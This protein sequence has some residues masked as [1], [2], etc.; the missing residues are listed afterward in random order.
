[1]V[2]TKLEGNDY[3]TSYHLPNK[4]VAL[5]DYIIITMACNL[6]NGN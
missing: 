2:S 3:Y 5:L 6:I 1:M 4:M